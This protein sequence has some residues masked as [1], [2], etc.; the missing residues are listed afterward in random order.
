M[1]TFQ[2]TWAEAYKESV[3]KYGKPAFASYTFFSKLWRPMITVG[4][5]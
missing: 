2:K 3:A 1:I 5:L 4:K